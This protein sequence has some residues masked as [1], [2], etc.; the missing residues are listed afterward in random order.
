MHFS[1]LFSRLPLPVSR[2]PL[3]KGLWSI[4]S[5]VIWNNKGCVN[6]NNMN[7]I[8]TW[9]SQLM[10][11]IFQRAK[12]SSSIDKMVIFSTVQK[13]QMQAKIK[14]HWHVFPRP[15]LYC[16]TLLPQNIRQCCHC[17]WEEGKEPWFPHMIFI[18]FNVSKR[19]N[20]HHAAVWHNQ[21]VSFSFFF[22]NQ[23][24]SVALL[25]LVPFLNPF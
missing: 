14:S 15:F 11:L 20:C 22:Y 10:Y 13:T 24:H 12:P 4:F 18:M 7:C 16:K 25:L 6:I 21:N 5:W 1:Y 8:S 9:R 23:R 17:S 2:N 19:I 3:A